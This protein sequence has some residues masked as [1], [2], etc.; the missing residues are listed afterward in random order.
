MPA[1]RNSG[2]TGTVAGLFINH[3][4]ETGL[5]TE[6]IEAVTVNYAGFEGNSYSG[7]TRPSCSRVRHQYEVG[8]EIRNTRQVSIL[9]QEELAEIADRLEIEKVQP[10]WLG[11]NLCLTGI[12]DFTHVTPSA[13][14]I[15]ESGA[16]LVVDMENHPCKY[17]GEVIEKFH[18]GKGKRFPAAAIH[19]RGVTAWVEREGLIKHGDLV[20]LHLPDQRRLYN[21]EG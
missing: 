4:R 14:L 19:R 17:P 5:Q 2:I 13:R 3:N 7:L 10:E 8:T 11:A 6:A 15:F 16:S 21:P 20:S 1:L 12:P 18:P 9:S